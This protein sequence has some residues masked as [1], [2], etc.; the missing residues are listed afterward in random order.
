MPDE[1]TEP[2]RTELYK[3]LVEKKPSDQAIRELGARLAEGESI[4]TVLA[5]LEKEC[6]EHTTDSRNEYRTVTIDDPVWHGNKIGQTRQYAYAGNRDAFD[7]ACFLKERRKDTEGLASYLRE[8]LE[9]AEGVHRERHGERHAID[10]DF[11][12]ALEQRLRKQKKVVAA[13]IKGLLRP[14]EHGWIDTER[15]GRLFSTYGVCGEEILQAYLEAGRISEAVCHAETIK[16]DSRKVIDYLIEHR[17]DPKLIRGTLDDLGK[18][19]HRK[20]IV[21]AAVQLGQVGRL[22]KQFI[23]ERDVESVVHAAALLRGNLAFDYEGRTRRAVEALES[24]KVY[25]D[26]AQLRRELEAQKRYRDAE[27]L[28]DVY[29]IY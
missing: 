26:A 22:F 1:K 21:D 12:H 11:S 29:R 10:L 28:G 24:S 6:E 2:D 8:C 15:I 19:Q 5:A 17:N 25:E 23:K 18:P 14:G 20:E 4:D 27:R 9:F 13:Y 3:Q 16:A 7:W